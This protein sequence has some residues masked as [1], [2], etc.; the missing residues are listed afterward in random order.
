MC[1]HIYCSYSFPLAFIWFTYFFTVRKKHM[2][3]HGSASWRSLSG[4]QL[5]LMEQYR[6][7]DSRVRT[8]YVHFLASRTW[9]GFYREFYTCSYRRRISSTRNYISYDD[10]VIPP[11]HI[12]VAVLRSRACHCAAPFS[13]HKRERQARRYHGRAHRE[14]ADNS[15][16]SQ[17]QHT[18]LRIG[19]H[20]MQ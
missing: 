5:K 17:N 2:N 8:A 11:I 10:T 15:E 9:N 16:L 19:H 13:H 20:A 6:A 3:S 18:A 12:G 4:S 14:Y 1:I 7:S